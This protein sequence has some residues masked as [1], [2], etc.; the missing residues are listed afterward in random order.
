LIILPSSVY[1]F[2]NDPNNKNIIYV[3]NENKKESLKKAFINNNLINIIYTYYEEFFE[4]DTT[5]N[6]TTFIIL[7]PYITINANNNFEDDIKVPNYFN[8]IKFPNLYILPEKLLYNEN[9]ADNLEYQIHTLGKLFLTNFIGG[10]I[11]ETDYADFWLISGIEN[12]LSDGFLLK[13][14]GNV[15]LKNK[16]S[17]QMRKYKKLIKKGKEKKPMYNNQ[18]THPA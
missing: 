1:S 2:L 11:C 8:I 16:V 6:N 17:E 12:W 14:F 15:Y 3:V 7:I 10:L 18:F 4:P 9:V 5:M 13:F